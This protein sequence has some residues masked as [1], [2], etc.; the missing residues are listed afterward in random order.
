MTL[1]E[2]KKTLKLKGLH[3]L[4]SFYGENTYAIEEAV[5]QVIEAF[6][7]KDADDEAIVR[8]DGQVHEVSQILET[9]KTQ[10]LFSEKRV[11]IVKKTHLLEEKQKSLFNNYFENPSQSCC[12]V[13]TAEKNPLK[14]VQQKLFKKKGLEINISPPKKRGEKESFINS[15]LKE[16]NLPLSRDAKTY[17]MENAGT[18]IQLIRNELEKLSL[19]CIGKNVVSIDDIEDT[20]SFENNVTIFRFVDELGM[21]NLENSLVNNYKLISK[22]VFP[23]V[24]LAMVIRQFRL[25]TIAKEALSKGDSF[26][27]ITKL[28]SFKY[29]FQTENIIKQAKGWKQECLNKVF[30]IF[31]STDTGFKSSS[32]SPGIV[33]EHMIFKICNLKNQA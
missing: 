8:F 22:R 29:D 24:I 27:Q 11:I 6:L 31:L 3:P 20:V 5:K 23:L 33:L 16:F 12:L 32:K 7:G 4:Y 1:D 30:E 28:L 19:F 26:Q 25:I 21:G 2:I 17:F 18:D 10:P 15:C 9:A 14:S 13:L